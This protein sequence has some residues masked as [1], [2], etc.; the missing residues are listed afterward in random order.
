MEDSLKVVVDDLVEMFGHYMA[1]FMDLDM[2][3][4]LVEHPAICQCHHTHLKWVIIIGI[5]QWFH[6]FFLMLHYC[7]NPKSI[8]KLVGTHNSRLSV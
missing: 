5:I 3:L 6:I 2:I 1:W 8:P 7:M 4:H